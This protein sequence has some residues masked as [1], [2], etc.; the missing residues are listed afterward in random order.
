MER[1]AGAEDSTPAQ[2][3]ALLAGPHL[4][5]QT[6]FHFSRAKPLVTSLYHTCDVFTN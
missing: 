4:G 6:E 1:S 2:L 5:G 3:P